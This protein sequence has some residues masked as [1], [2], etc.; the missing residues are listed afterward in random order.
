VGTLEEVR[1]FQREYMPVKFGSALTSKLAKH[2]WERPNAAG[3]PL[4]FAIQDFSAPLSM[5]ITRSA[6]PVYLYGYDHDWAHD[7]SGKLHITPRKISEHRWG[8]KV[9]PSGFFDLPGAEHVSAVIFSNSGTISKFNRMGF[10]AGFGSKRVKLV[11]EGFAVDHDPNTTNPRAFRHEVNDDG[12]SESWVEGLDVFHNP[13]AL[14]PIDPR[15]LPGAG[16]HRLL[17]DG[18]MESMTPQWQPLSSVTRIFVPSDTD[19]D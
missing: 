12:Y 3:K 11:R 14:L 18:Q 10:V 5:L 16:H 15:V 2:Y 7:E 8:G 6:L 4:L 13:N 9:I 17:P 1:A 19:V